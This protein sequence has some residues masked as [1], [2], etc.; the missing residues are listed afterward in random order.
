ML[1]IPEK[2]CCCCSV[3]QLCLTLCIS[4]DAAR[5]ASL[6]LSISRSL[7]KFKY[8]AIHCIGED[9]QSSHPLFPSSPSAVNLSQHQGLRVSHSQTFLDSEGGYF[10]T[11]F[12][13]G[14]TP[15]FQ[16]IVALAQS[17]LR[18]EARKALG[19][20]CEIHLRRD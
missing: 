17:N 10:Q 5:Q 6:S 19:M 16:S 3:D 11:P 9:S 8:I 13:P 2:S 14:L 1:R 20:C 7:P 15:P 4:M 12:P 18:Q